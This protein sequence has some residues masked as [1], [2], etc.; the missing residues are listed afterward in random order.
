MSAH[1]MGSSRV[2]ERDTAD[3]PA[4]AEDARYRRVLVV[5]EDHEFAQSAVVEGIELARVAHAD[6]VFLQIL[7]ELHTPSIGVA[8]FMHMPGQHLQRASQMASERRAAAA[9]RAASKAGV[10]AKVASGRV[11]RSG[12]GIAAAA[13]ELGCDLIVV[14]SDG[15]NAVARLLMGSVIPGLVTAATASVLICRGGGASFIGGRR[16]RRAGRASTGI[17]PTEVPSAK[18]DVPSGPPTPSL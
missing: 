3:R 1:M 12:A 4:Q 10:P 13:E 9:M 11:A 18:A 15:H 17:S 14:A 5:L 2:P 16:R 8:G 6:V 7:A